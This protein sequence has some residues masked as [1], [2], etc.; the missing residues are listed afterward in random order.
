M[1]Y[2]F[3]QS[4]TSVRPIA[5]LIVNESGYDVE[6]EWIAEILGCDHVERED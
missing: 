3:Y 5:T 2:M 4:Q 1:K 6:M